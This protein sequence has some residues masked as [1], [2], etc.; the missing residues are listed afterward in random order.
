MM[1][2]WFVSQQAQQAGLY[3]TLS[4]LNQDTLVELFTIDATNLGGGIHRFTTTPTETP[5]VWGGNSYPFYPVETS[6]WEWNGRGALPTPTLTV[7]RVNN[8]FHALT[9][10]Y[11]DLLGAV[12]TRHRTFRR[13]LDDGSSP[14]T[15]MYLPFDVYRIERKTQ[16]TKLAISW[17]LSAYLDQE[18]Q[19]IP[20]R[21]VLRD[22][23]LHRYRKYNAVSGLF[24][25]SKAT[26]PY[27]GAACFDRQ[28]NTTTDPNDSCGKRL[29][30]CKLRFGENA[31]LPTRKFPGVARQR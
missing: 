16:A 26:C 30:D 11:N 8:V 9:V 4:Q 17:E 27:A 3:S 18:G 23:C 15:S 28:G 21:Q 12:V 22:T 2:M 31:E 10:T 19:N 24:D 7:S 1:W 6:G 13:Y 20:R 14:D 5:L 29:S 25:Y